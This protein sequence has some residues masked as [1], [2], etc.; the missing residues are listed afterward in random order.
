MDFA[1]GSKFTTSS[2]LRLEPLDSGCQV[3]TC[4]VKHAV[5]RNCHRLVE[6]LRFLRQQDPICRNN[7]QVAQR[8]SAPL[9]YLKPAQC[10]S[11]ERCCHTQMS[12][13]VSCTAAGPWGLIGTIED[14]MAAQV[15]SLS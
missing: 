1:G 4:C 6:A 7:T 8:C 13:E 9:S 15:S 2:L 10:L 5:V 14:T 3:W 11:F 12:A